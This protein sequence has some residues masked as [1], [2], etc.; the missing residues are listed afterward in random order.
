MNLKRMAQCARIYPKLANYIHPDD[1]NARI[2][3][4]MEK[5]RD[6]AKQLAHDSL[7]CEMS[8]L[9][10]AGFDPNSTAY[11]QKKDHILTRLK[12]LQPGEATSLNA[13]K[14]DDGEIVTDAAAIAAALQTQWAKVFASKPI[15][16]QLLTRW[17]ESSIGARIQGAT[18]TSGDTPTS[19]DS[20][21]QPGIPL[22]STHENW[23][24]RRESRER[25]I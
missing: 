6:H 17:L 18:T 1:P 8:A 2:K 20:P 11:R 7:A 19:M 15:D 22:S 10:K 5:L 14:N 9:G 16:G 23:T 12:K 4:A 13:I 24:V 21:R 25:S 3:P